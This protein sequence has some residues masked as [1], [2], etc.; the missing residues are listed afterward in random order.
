M[1]SQ[2]QF[3][4]LK[5]TIFETTTKSSRSFTLH[6]HALIVLV[7]QAD[8]QRLTVV[9]RGHTVV[10]ARIVVTVVDPGTAT[11]VVVVTK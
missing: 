7:G 6:G 11:C 10:V 8:G 3:A 2:A 4:W 1:R 5:G 9:T